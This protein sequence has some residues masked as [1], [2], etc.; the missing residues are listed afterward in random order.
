[1]SKSSKTY[2]NILVSYPYAKPNVLQPLIDNK[3]DIRFLLDSGA[4]TAWKKGD[5]IK[6]KDYLKFIE[7]LPV[8]PWKYFA[9]DVIGE[10]K[11]TKAN[12][13][14]MLKDG[15]KPIPIFTRG[16]DPAMIEKFYKTSEVV[17]IGGLV[18]TRRNRG[19]VKG[20]MEVVGDRKAHWLGFNYHPFLSHYKPFMC[21]SSSWLTS[22]RFAALKLYDKKGKWLSIKKTDFIQRPSKNVLDL[23]S[24]YDVDP[25]RLAHVGEWKVSG[26]GESA[27]EIVAARSWVKYQLDIEK[28]LGT[29]FFMACTT[30]WQLEIAIEAYK[31]WKGKGL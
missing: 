24:S 1:M 5:P 17:A 18:G 4:F 26:N 8:K 14:E 6:L 22:F 29:K 13:K 23:I 12:Y 11:K 31:Y 28:I 3:K 10:S 2:L 16:E 27:S 20:I 25:T 21:D 15:Y 7:D 19:F 9:L 30:K